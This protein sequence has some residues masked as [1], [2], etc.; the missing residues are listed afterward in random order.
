MENFTFNNPTKLIFGRDTLDELKTEIP[1]YGSRILIT[2]GG[3]SI[4]RNGIYDR[5]LDLLAALDMQIFELSGIE[6]NPRL[7]TVYEGITLCREEKID[8]I[9]AI[10]GGSVIDATKAIA[11]GALYE[12]DVWDIITGQ[13]E[14]KKALPFGTVLTIA[15]TGSEMNPISVITNW[16]TKE[17]LLWTSPYVYPTFSILDPVH[18]FSVPKEQ[19]IYGAVDIMSH[20]MEHYF[21]AASNT[22]LNE[23]MVESLL[24]TVME[25]TPKVLANP[26]D[27]EGRATLLFCG[28]MAFNGV[29]NQGMNGDWSTH[30]IEHA[31]SA[32][33]DI[34]HGGGIGIIFPHWIH[35]H[36]DTTEKKMKQLAI[37]V[38]EVDPVGKSDREIAEEGLKR[39]RQT[40]DQFGAPNRLMDYQIDDQRLL[41]MASKAA[42]SGRIGG[43]APSTLE[44]V[45][46]ILKSSL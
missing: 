44:D 42:P 17:K 36:L 33:Y 30:V 24:T 31:V 43:F 11:V 7:T 46:E 13:D 40:W 10:G 8:F 6:A 37:R 1:K 19:T 15:A 34:P 32:V 5:T 29:L 41:E 27:Y 28:T 18:T 25:A 3:G 23:R 26:E 21:S 38:F 16:E 9:L 39:L 20:A 12:G 22:P 2:Y 14:A 45:T 4:K 35:H